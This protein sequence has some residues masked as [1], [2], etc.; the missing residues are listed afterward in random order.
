MNHATHITENNVL[1]LRQC[2][3]T[4]DHI[5]K[6]IIASHVSAVIIHDA[7]CDACEKR[8]AAGPHESEL[9]SGRFHTRT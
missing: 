1:S 7:A 8:L 6:I 5:R 9:T 2:L 4:T 3:A